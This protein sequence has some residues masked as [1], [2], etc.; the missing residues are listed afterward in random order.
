MPN[1]HYPDAFLKGKASRFIALIAACAFAVTLFVGC[2]T[3]P[4]SSEEEAPITAS[5]YMVNLNDCSVRLS[6]KLQ[7]FAEAV[8]DDKVSAMQTKA[9]EAYA[10]LDEMSDLEAPEDVN[11][12]KAKY[13]EASNKMKDA[14]SS[15][16]A[17]YTEVFDSAQAVPADYAQRI[18]D[19]QKQYDAALNALEEADKMS[20]EM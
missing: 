1:M 2:T 7:G 13:T 14:L 15:Y 10:I 8:A 12:L 17:L 3:T 11:D 5:E 19:V 20:T 6:D 18:E 4:S 16:V 9:E